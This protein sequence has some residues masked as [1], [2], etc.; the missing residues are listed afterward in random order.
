MPLP[1]SGRA[2][3]R[4]NAGAHPASVLHH[5]ADQ[6]VRGKP[7]HTVA[8]YR[9]TWRLLL[10]YVADTTGTAPQALALSALTAELISAISA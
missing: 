10:R 4:D 7:A 8:A 1:D 6:P 3:G 2:S 5:P 9:D